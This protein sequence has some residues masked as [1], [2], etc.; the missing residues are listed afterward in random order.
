MEAALVLRMPIRLGV[1]AR[2]VS[3]YQRGKVGITYSVPSSTLDTHLLEFLTLI[4]I[5]TKCKN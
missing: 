3:E 2:W 5:D 1:K 4:E